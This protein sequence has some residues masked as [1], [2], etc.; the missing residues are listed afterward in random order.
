MG[1]NLAHTEWRL[2]LAPH[3]DRAP[4]LGIGEPAG[5]AIDPVDTIIDAGTSSR[6]GSQFSGECTQHAFS[7]SW[8]L[9]A[10][11]IHEQGNHGYRA[12]SYTGGTNLFTPQLPADDPDQ[13]TYVLDDLRRASLLLLSLLCGAYQDDAAGCF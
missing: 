2:E 1:R 6:D 3:F 11:Y 10:D 7:A 8:S 4:A 9:S 5:L 12:Y 13:A